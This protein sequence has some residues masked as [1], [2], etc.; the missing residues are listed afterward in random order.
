M[1]DVAIDQGAFGKR[2]KLLY[3]SWKVRV[4]SYGHLY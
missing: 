4:V 2:L 1:G 3:E